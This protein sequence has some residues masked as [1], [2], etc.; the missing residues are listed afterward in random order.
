MIKPLA[1]FAATAALLASPAVAEPPELDFA[2]LV[3]PPPADGSPRQAAELAEVHR[4]LA[5][6]SPERLAQAIWDDKHED[7]TL[8]A[9]VLGPGF[10]LAKLP[11]TR[12]V[13]AGIDGRRK[14]AEGAKGFFKRKRPW[15]Y[16]PT[17]TPCDGGDKGKNPLSSY[18]SGHSL[19][20]YSLGMTL[21]ALIPDKAQ[22]IEA[23][24]SDYAYSREV[25][26]AHYHSDT[27]ASHVLAAVLV[28][29]YLRDP[30]NADGIDAARNE[31]KAAGL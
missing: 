10:D 30:A 31:L 22:A 21:A 29:D 26:G 1:A 3:P 18:P 19:T 12:A 24:A 2:R 11:V 6:R 15:A 13:L 4:L 14:A 8:F 5:M 27:E 20:G 17:I 9:D 16:D 7:A 23:R 28:T 25:C